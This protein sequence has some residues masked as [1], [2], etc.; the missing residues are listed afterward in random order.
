MLSLDTTTHRLLHRRPCRAVGIAWRVRGIDAVVK[1]PCGR[2]LQ[3]VHF[4]W[5]PGRRREV[6][7]KDWP[8]EL[9]GPHL[10]R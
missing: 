2:T 5:L 7:D 6:I 4:T 1:A 10:H 8:F 3:A 9:P